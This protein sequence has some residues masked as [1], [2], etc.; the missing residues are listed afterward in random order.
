[1]SNRHLFKA[2]MLDINAKTNS[3]YHQMWDYL[4]FEPIK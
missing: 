1:S 4:L 3:V 2:I